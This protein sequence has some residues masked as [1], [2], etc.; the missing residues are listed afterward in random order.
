MALPN[1]WLYYSASQL[2]HIAMAL[3]PLTEREMNLLDLFTLLLSF[4]VGVG[5]ADGL[6]TL[7]FSRSKNY[8]TYP[9][10]QKIWNKVRMMQNVTGFTR[11]SP[12][13]D[14]NYYHEVAKLQCG[15]KWRQ[16]GIIHMPHIFSN[17]KLRPFSELQ[18][19]F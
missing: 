10:M 11:Y 3:R 4:T 8:P 1:P 14:N 17:G 19:T 18:S 2:Q 7:H 16:Y 15:V 9:P 12:I 6:E 13:W 5:V